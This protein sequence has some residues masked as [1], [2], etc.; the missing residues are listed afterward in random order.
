[1]TCDVIKYRDGST[2]ILCNRGTKNKRCEF[3]REPA[4]YQCDGESK[5]RRS[6]TCDKR[7]CEEHRTSMGDR[8]LELVED[9]IDYCPTCAA[10]GHQLKLF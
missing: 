9:T 5:T 10:G 3:C 6:G 4:K 1:M 2:F 8:G 7:M